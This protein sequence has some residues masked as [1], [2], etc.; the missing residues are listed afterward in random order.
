ME[1]SSGL[2]IL[3]NKK[4]LLIQPSG[5]SFPTGHYS[6]PKGNVHPDENIQ[7]A[8]IRETFEETGILIEKSLL[9]EQICIEYIN[10]GVC[11]KKVFC[12]VVRLHDEDLPDIIPSKQLQHEEVSSAAFYTRKEAL[13]LLFWRF[14]H[15][16]FELKDFNE[17]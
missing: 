13:F 1:M 6:V 2:I 5:T 3:K 15:L 12:F 7:D 4:I 14:R 8:A 11:T 17:D 16:L 10:N 9:E